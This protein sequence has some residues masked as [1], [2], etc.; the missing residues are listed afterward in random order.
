MRGQVLGVQSIEGRG[1]MQMQELDSG[2]QHVLLGV[3]T[4]ITLSGV[5]LSLEGHVP[6][7]RCRVKVE[8]TRGDCAGISRQLSRKDCVSS[9]A[10]SASEVVLESRSLVR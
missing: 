4:A 6:C 8:H 2:L 9:S 1:R 3:E 7:L 5:T 10:G